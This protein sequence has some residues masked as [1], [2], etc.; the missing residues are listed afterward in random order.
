[1]G[2]AFV[3]FKEKECVNDTIEEMDL[4]KTKLVGKDQY[5]TL[6]IK[7]WEVEVAYPNNDI[8]WSELNRMKGRMLIVKILLVLLPFLV[9]VVV[10]MMMVY[11]D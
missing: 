9:S 8:I 2:V 1:V 11:F 10:S 6:D 4:V 3:S 7:N 5:D